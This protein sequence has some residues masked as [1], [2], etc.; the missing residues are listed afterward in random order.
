MYYPD[1]IIE[2]VRIR[3]DII[4]VIGSHKFKEVR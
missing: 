2:E 3:N 1:E 4:G